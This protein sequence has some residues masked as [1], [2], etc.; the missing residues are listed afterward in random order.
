MKIG[1]YG[2]YEEEDGYEPFTVQEAAVRQVHAYD[3]IFRENM[4]A[5][6][7]GLVKNLLNIHTVSSEE[8]PD[9][10]QFTKEREPDLLKKVTDTDGN[11]FILHL[12]IQTGNE[13]TN[14]PFR[15]A[16]YLIMLTRKYHL[17]VL[18][19]VIYIGEQPLT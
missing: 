19:Y 18:Q 3:K 13:A 5:V 16:E 10:L 9:S 6:L 11:I 7:P 15:M 14:M 1:Y 2:L 4:E 17:P 12:E 8:I